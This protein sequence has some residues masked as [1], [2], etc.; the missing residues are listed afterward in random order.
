MGT[1]STDGTSVIHAAVLFSAAA[2]VVCEDG[3]TGTEA[4]AFLSDRAL[5]KGIYTLYL[6]C[7]KSLK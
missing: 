2:A 3:G 1:C 4:A 6:A 5:W 7:W